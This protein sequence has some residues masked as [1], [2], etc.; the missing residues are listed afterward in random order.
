MFLEGEVAEGVLKGAR[1]EGDVYGIGFSPLDE[2]FFDFF[3]DGDV[4]LSVSLGLV[5]EVFC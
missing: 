2:V 5:L 3:H 4:V 1:G